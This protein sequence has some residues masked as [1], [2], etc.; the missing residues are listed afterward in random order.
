M[1]PSL[2]ETFAFFPSAGEGLPESAKTQATPEG[3][4]GSFITALAKAMD[5]VHCSEEVEILPGLSADRLE[6][7]DVAEAASQHAIPGAAYDTS[8]GHFQSSD[9]EPEDVGNE[10]SVITE[11]NHW[12]PVIES[13]FYAKAVEQAEITEEELN[14]DTEEVVM[15]DDSGRDYK[16]TNSFD[17]AEAV[18]GTSYGSDA[19][20][21][22]SEKP[23][24]PEGNQVYE[25]VDIIKKVP[26]PL[27]DDVS[28]QPL[29]VSGYTPVLHPTTK[30]EEDDADEDLTPYN[31]SSNE[32]AG[33]LKVGMAVV[34]EIQGELAR[35]VSD[36]QSESVARTDAATL[37]RPAVNEHPNR[38]VPSYSPASSSAV[39]MPVVHKAEK[40]FES[41]DVAKGS[42]SSVQ[43]ESS[44]TAS[45]SLPSPSL[46]VTPA[47][48]SSTS[49]IPPSS[50][51]HI[52]SDMTLR[53]GQIAELRESIP[54]KPLSDILLRV[55]DNMEKAVGK[56]PLTT[57]TIRLNQR[58]GVLSASIA[59]QDPGRAELVANRASGLL[60]VLQSHGLQP[61]VMHVLTP[62][63]NDRENTKDPSR[64][65]TGFQ[66]Y[67]NRPKHRR[68]L[69][70]KNSI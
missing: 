68:I 24:L 61:G 43:S 16:P 29:I 22:L 19:A 57:D 64:D 8:E 13:E 54:V 49:Q 40:G 7:H 53:V 33:D 62:R 2:I 6:S 58:D 41:G 9:M 44:T 5:G 25:E 45:P 39:P 21:Y 56:A 18:E 59:I 36:P 63:N 47:T 67:R 27:D 48:N 11:D 50:T 55:G 69:E 14:I 12:V 10:S 35:P 70:D 31:V 52:P 66:V 20:V 1:M 60:K 37:H 28:D 38:T 17:A 65:W 23:G 30:P 34:P 32:M 46:S 15:Q 26:L 3:G 4:A 42:F 51:V